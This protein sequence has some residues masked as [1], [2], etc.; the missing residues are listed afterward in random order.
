MNSA[1]VETRVSED[2]V[3]GA[4]QI[5]RGPAPQTATALLGRQKHPVAFFECWTERLDGTE[6]SKRHG[7]PR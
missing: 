6:R 3:H 2:L 1:R 4:L 7:S 5:G